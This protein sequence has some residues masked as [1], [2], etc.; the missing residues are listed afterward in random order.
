MSFT[1]II[2]LPRLN[3][4]CL[5]HKS[6]YPAISIPILPSRCGGPNLQRLC[7]AFLLLRGCC[8]R[9]TL[10]L[11]GWP[12]ALNTASLLLR[13]CCRCSPLGLFRCPLAL[14]SG[15]GL[16][17]GCD[18]GGLDPGMAI[19]RAVRDHLQP[20]LELSGVFLFILIYGRYILP[21][22]CNH[23]R[24]RF[25]TRGCIRIIMPPSVISVIFYHGVI[26][27]RRGVIII[28]SIGMNVGYPH[29][30]VIFHATKMVLPDD[31][32]MV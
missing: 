1:I 31:N 14:G 10:G 22:P 3:L 21:Y 7:T 5:I 16:H 25:F 6:F 9:Y 23:V 4:V 28:D 12:L 26:N 2:L 27:D 15:C 19:D 20:L 11:F 17:I 13:G 8:R 32:G 30:T 24:P 29:R 18:T